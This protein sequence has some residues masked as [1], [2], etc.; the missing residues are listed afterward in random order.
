MKTAQTKS[1]FEKL[2]VI[3]ALVLISMALAAHAADGKED[4]TSDIV[5]RKDYNI[6]KD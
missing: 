5:A 6:S 1:L 3:A 2:S 4:Q